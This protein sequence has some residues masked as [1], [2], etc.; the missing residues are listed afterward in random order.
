MHAWAGA[1][2]YFGYAF[3]WLRILSTNIW[4][5]FC[6][7]FFLFSFIFLSALARCHQQYGCA[8]SGGYIC[9]SRWWGFSVSVWFWKSCCCF[10]RSSLLLSFF[11][12]CAFPLYMYSPLPVFPS[13]RHQLLDGWFKQ[14]N[15]LLSC[16]CVSFSPF[17]SV[18]FFSSWFFSFYFQVVRCAT[19]SAE[20]A[21]YI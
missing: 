8:P 19:A 4:R 12:V 7:L 17:F 15:S 2:S 10:C 21:P 20:K 11:F 5:T 16:F 1:E 14:L 9:L 13:P 3:R 18:L 6:W